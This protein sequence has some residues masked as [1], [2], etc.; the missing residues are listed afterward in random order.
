MFI[1]DAPI[2][3]TK[4]FIPKPRQDLISRPRL[5]EKLNGGLDRKLTLISAPAGFGKS[6]LISDWIHQTKEDIVWLSLDENDNNQARFL[7]YL[8]TALSKAEVI[9]KPISRGALE[10]LKSP[11]VP[12]YVDILT[13]LINEVAALSGN[14]IL[15]LDD[16]HLIDSSPIDESLSFLL[17]NQ[18]QNFH[19][20]IATRDDPQLSLAR[21][22]ARGQLTELRAADLRFTSSEA[23]DFLNNV[24]GLA[25]YPFHHWL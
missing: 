21:L 13:T 4:L 20:I 6:T 15:V 7:T 16:Y 25:A 17:E 18:P 8:I 14:I 9:E 11:Q 1:M 3:S 5:F 22:R 2:L 23:V 12:S 19:L 10:M 24:M